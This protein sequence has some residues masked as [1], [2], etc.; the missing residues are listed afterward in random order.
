[1]LRWFGAPSECVPRPASS[2]QRSRSSCLFFVCTKGRAAVK[3]YEEASPPGATRLL[4]ISF[5]RFEVL[6]TRSTLAV[7]IRG[8]DG[9]PIADSNLRVGVQLKRHGRAYVSIGSVPADGRMRVLVPVQFPSDVR[10]PQPVRLKAYA[11]GPGYVTTWTESFV[12]DL[13]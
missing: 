6:H 8:A 4:E 10:P 3:V 9:S 12:V 13:R 5:P 7:N 1:M 2:W 11:K